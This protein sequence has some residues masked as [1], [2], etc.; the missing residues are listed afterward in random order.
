MTFTCQWGRVKRLFS[1][2]EYFS[3]AERRRQKP[4]VGSCS[5]KW[6]QP[7]SSYSQLP[8]PPTS[9]W[10]GTC[11]VHPEDT[12]LPLRPGLKDPCIHG[13]LD[14]WAIS[15]F[16]SFQ[17]HSLKPKF[18]KEKKSYQRDKSL[19]CTDILLFLHFRVHGVHFC[20]WVGLEREDVA[21]ISCESLK[22]LQVS[23][24]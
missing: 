11:V 19:W 1:F 17:S 9:P 3:A 10:A 12:N 14:P 18:K 15:D 24:P 21:L 8:S 20:N 13:S 7:S 6:G 23:I 22:S 16:L 4:G 2:C 5:N